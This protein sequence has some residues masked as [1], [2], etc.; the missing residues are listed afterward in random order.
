MTGRREL[1]GLLDRLPEHTAEATR[2]VLGQLD[3]LQQAISGL[4]TEIARTYAVSRELKL[5]CSLPGVGPIL[6]VVILAEIGQVSRFASGERL[7]SYAG[8]VPRVHASGDK[9]YTGRVRRDTNGYLQWAFV[10]AANAALL[11][12]GRYRHVQQLYDRVRDRRG[13]KKAIVAVARHLAEASY[14][15]LT[16]SQSY[17]EPRQ[18][19]R[20]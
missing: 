12:K 8:T 19:M 16:K 14:W 10:E 15:V 18:P 5:L 1:T 9:S 13:H 3:S 7:A 2:L 11:H 4:E 20:G 6:S 17:Q